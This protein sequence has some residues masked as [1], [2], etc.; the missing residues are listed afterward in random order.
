MMQ[1]SVS[2]V[3]LAK[4][5]VLVCYYLLPFHF[6]DKKG[7]PHFSSSYKIRCISLIDWVALLFITRVT[8]FYN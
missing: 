4:K 1:L 8:E 5:L 7:S 2:K 6:S 3:E